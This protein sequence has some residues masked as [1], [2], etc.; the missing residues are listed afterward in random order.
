MD[1]DPCRE[2]PT[3]RDAIPTTE[4]GPMSDVPDPPPI[5]VAP[6]GPRRWVRLAPIPC[7]HRQASR[8][9]ILQA[10]GRVRPGRAIALGA[11]RCREIPLAELADRFEHVTLVDL[12]AAMLD[13]ALAGAGL[14]GSRGARVERRVADLTGVTD[15][16]LE[17][18]DG[19]LAAT[20]EESVERLARLAQA[21]RPEAFAADGTYDLVIASCVLCQLHLAA[22]HGAA[23]R[24]ASRFPGQ[25]PLLSQSSVWFHALYGLARR[26]EDAFVEALRNLVAPGGRI[27]LSDTVQGAL[28]HP[29]PDGHWMTEGLFRM[30]RT[31]LLSDYL[32]GRF[33]VEDRGGWHWIEEPSGAPGQPGKLF[34][35][36]ALVLAVG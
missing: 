6:A 7:P 14:E 24:F 8:G 27:F 1:H 26:M 17:G 4:L 35:V 2:R 18:V 9:M 25:G 12:D 30:T 20:P 11:G 15:R 28:L 33:R 19:C 32:D 21:T 3:T 22:C 36:Q 13:D 16:F 29:A 10:A 34:N 23:A 31:P 5:A